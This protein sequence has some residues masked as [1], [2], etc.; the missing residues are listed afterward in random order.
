MAASCN[1]W[2]HW[3]NAGTKLQQSCKLHT[4]ADGRTKVAPHPTAMEWQLKRHYET[5][6]GSECVRC[7][8]EFIS[9]QRVGEGASGRSRDGIGCGIKRFGCNKIN[10]IVGA[11]FVCCFSWLLCK[12]A[13]VGVWLCVCMWVCVC[14]LCKLLGGL[15]STKIKVVVATT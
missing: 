6:S 14:L 9:R 8:V 12:S 13:C 7:L 10:L 4:S 2:A 5:L 11:A 1:N 3:N 15:I